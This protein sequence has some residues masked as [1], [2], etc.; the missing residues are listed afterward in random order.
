MD[1]CTVQGGERRKR[2]GASGLEDVAVARVGVTIFPL[3]VSSDGCSKGVGVTETT[4]VDMVYPMVVGSKAG[5]VVLSVLQEWLGSWEIIFGLRRSPA[6]P[7]P[8]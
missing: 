3:S 2:I 4:G 8:L 7:A 6:R 5:A 1:A